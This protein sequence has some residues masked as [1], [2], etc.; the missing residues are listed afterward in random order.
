MSRTPNSQQSPAPEP[1][2]EPAYCHDLLSWRIVRRWVFAAVCLATLTGLFYAVENWRGKRAWEHC[3]RELEAKGA[4]I[5]WNALIPPPV[6]DEQNI[7]KAPK[8]AEWFVKGS[9]A[10]AVSG[11]PSKSGNTNAPFSLAPHQES[12]AGPVL[13]AEVDVVPSNGPPPPG[14][15][16]AALRLDDPAAREPAAKLLRESIGPCVEGV[17]N[18]VIIAQPLDHIKPANLVVQADTVPTAKALAEFLPR[19]PVPHNL[20][21]SSDPNFFQVDSLGSKTFRVSLKS[22]VYS[23]AEY[24]T[25]SQPAVADLDLLREALKCPCARMDSDYERPFER[26]LPNFVRMRTVAQIESQRT[27]CYLLLGQSAAAWHELSLVRDLC[28]ILEARPASDCPTLVEA[29]I[30]VAITGLYAQTVAD[31]L[32]LRAWREPE[33]VA[34][35]RQLK[36]INLLPLVRA[37]M[38]AERA[39]MCRTFEITPAAEFKKWFFLGDEPQG[40]WGKLKDPRFLLIGFT[41]RGWIYQNMCALAI[42]DQLTSEIFDVPNDQ[43]LPR[44]ADK[45]MNQLQTALGHFTPYTFLGARATP[46]FVKAAQ[47]LAQKQTLANEAFIACGLERYRLAH[48]QYPE[49]LEAL[50]PQFA[51]KLPHDIVGG[52]PLKYHRTADGQFV[53]YSIGWNEKDD[54]GVPGKTVAE[55]DWVWQ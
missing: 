6:P 35:Q 29:M 9:S 47:T 2:A 12:K 28:H 17:R 36:D 51:E 25:L 30:S 15:A 49:T 1:G 45:I 48:G 50:V 5:D 20:Y 19:R 24:L 10:P 42:R 39:G 53:L 40:L 22:P 52:Q 38:N 3:R 46:N 18:I 33:L 4:V 16:D 11:A 14:K 41:P 43:V 8:M 21:N 34:I 31:G 7:F 26:P 32:R 13:V 27:Q 44:K 54:G 55:G 23:A 37:S